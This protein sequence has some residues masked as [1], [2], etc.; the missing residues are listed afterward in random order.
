MVVKPLPQALQQAINQFSPQLNNN[1]YQFL[2]FE[3]VGGSLRPA[4]EP[5]VVYLDPKPVES[6]LSASPELEICGDVPLEPLELLGS[7]P[8]FPTTLLAPSV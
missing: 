2:R 4:R 3:I 5:T 6:A 8:S 1:T 7:C